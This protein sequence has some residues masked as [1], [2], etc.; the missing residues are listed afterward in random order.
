M[1]PF[2]ETETLKVL[3][4]REYPGYDPVF[5]GGRIKQSSFMDLRLTFECFCIIFYC[6]IV[7]FFYYLLS[8]LINFTVSIY[9]GI[10]PC[11]FLY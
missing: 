11:I 6:I 4:V 9:V 1:K 7:R 10:Y 2:V 8:L 5:T 3:D